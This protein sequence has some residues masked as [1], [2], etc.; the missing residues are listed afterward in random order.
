MDSEND[1][2]DCNTPRVTGKLVREQ[3]SSGMNGDVR[4]MDKV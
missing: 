2:R 4:T 1:I 3:N